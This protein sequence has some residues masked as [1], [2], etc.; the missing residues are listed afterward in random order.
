MKALLNKM[1]DYGLQ[2]ISQNR[3]IRVGR[4]YY[5]S[6]DWTSANVICHHAA[7][8]YIGNKTLAHGSYA[9]CVAHK[10]EWIESGLRFAIPIKKGEA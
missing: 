8:S 6:V 7:V 1:R 2:T 10:T 9:L 4:K 3:L 5:V